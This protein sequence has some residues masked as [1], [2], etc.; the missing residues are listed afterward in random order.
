M[1]GKLKHKDKIHSV[2]SDADTKIIKVHPKWE[3]LSMSTELTLEVAN[4]FENEIPAKYGVNKWELTLERFTE[5]YD[6]NEDQVKIKDEQLEFLF[7][8]KQIRK[9]AYR[10]KVGKYI[11]DFIGIF[12]FGPKTAMV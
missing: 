6:L 11:Y 8:S 4:Y 1:K 2:Y 3:T 5:T 7:Y 10:T 9:V 12:F